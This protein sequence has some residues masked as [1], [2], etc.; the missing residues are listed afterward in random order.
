MKC[1]LEP[2]PELPVFMRQSPAFLVQAQLSAHPGGDDGRIEGL[3]NVI[4]G[5]EGETLLLVFDSGQRRDKNDR[6]GGCCGPLLELPADI[7]AAQSG[8]VDI[9]QNDIRLRLTPGEFER[10]RA[11]DSHPDMV[12]RRQHILEQINIGRCIVDDEYGRAN[13]IHGR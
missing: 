10:L 5:T 4:H 9:E 11:V 3:G 1:A 13:I 6:Y 2:L 7:V 8:H 12:V